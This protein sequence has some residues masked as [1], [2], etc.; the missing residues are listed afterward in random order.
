MAG[1]NKPATRPMAP[2]ALAVASHGHQE[3]GIL[4]RSSGSMMNAA[5]ANSAQAES[6]TKAAATSVTMR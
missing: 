5:W 2:N 1:T 4:S 6:P 3:W